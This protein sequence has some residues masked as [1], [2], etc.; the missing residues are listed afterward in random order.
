MGLNLLYGEL[1]SDSD[2]PFCDGNCP[3]LPV[4][5]DIFSIENDVLKASTEDEGDTLLIDCNYSAELNRL[6]YAVSGLERGF[7]RII[8]SDNSGLCVGAVTPHIPS[9]DNY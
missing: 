1:V 9:L 3:L 6:D 5:M 2:I 8:V 7:Y 4:R